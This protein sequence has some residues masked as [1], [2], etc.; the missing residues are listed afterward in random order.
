MNCCLRISLLCRAHSCNFCFVKPF[1]CKNLYIVDMLIFRNS[2]SSNSDLS[3]RRFTAISLIDYLTLLFAILFSIP[4]LLNRHCSVFS[5]KMSFFWILAPAVSCTWSLRNTC[6]KKSKKL[7]ST[8]QFWIDLNMLLIAPRMTV[9]IL[10]ISKL[11]GCGH[12]I[13]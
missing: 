3:I 10:I 1:L 13:S 6:R 11:C 5:R 8:L 7:S 9:I 12:L 2:T 4:C